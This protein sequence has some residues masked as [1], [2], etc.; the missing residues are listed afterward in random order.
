MKCS[1]VGRNLFYSDPDVNFD[2]DPDPETTSS[3]T[4]FGKSEF[5][6]LKF[7]P[8]RIRYSGSDPAKLCGLTG[9]GSTTLIK[10]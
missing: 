1:V 9:S 10:S 3:F 8:I 7:T 6:K 5:L 4:H 2:D